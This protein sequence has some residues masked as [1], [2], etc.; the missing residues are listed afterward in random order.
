LDTWYAIHIDYTNTFNPKDVIQFASW[1]YSR[2]LDGEMVV[3]NENGVSHFKGTPTSVGC[4][5]FVFPIHQIRN[6]PP[7]SKNLNSQPV[8][9]VSTTCQ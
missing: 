5:F 1:K 4:L 8:Y 7:L 2:I 9:I 6:W 3:I